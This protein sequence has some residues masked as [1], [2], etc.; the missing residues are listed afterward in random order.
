MTEKQESLSPCKQGSTVFLKCQ[1]P[2][3]R[4][5]ATSCNSQ[6]T[7]RFICEGADRY[8]SATTWHSKVKRRERPF[9]GWQQNASTTSRS[10][11]TTIILISP[12]R[13]MTNSTETASTGSWKSTRRRR[14]MIDNMWLR[15]NYRRGRR[16]RDDYCPMLRAMK[17]KKVRLTYDISY[18]LPQANDDGFAIY[19]KNVRRK[20]SECSDEKPYA[21]MGHGCPIKYQGTR[22]RE[23]GRVVRW[24]T[25]NVV[26]YQRHFDERIE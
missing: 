16:R 13:T 17:A 1:D 22:S 19:N 2:E 5:H 9:Y 8:D 15:P 23:E 12:A 10:E 18:D 6:S 21:V 20:T 14:V 24:T 25:R 11:T 4:L 26:F 3:E 7:A